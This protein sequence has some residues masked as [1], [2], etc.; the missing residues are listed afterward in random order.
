[1]Y[2]NRLFHLVNIEDVI[3]KKP[4]KYGIDVTGRRGGIKASFWAR[5]YS[6]FHHKGPQS[7]PHTKNNSIIQLKTTEY[8]TE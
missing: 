5:F 1:M 4:I 2:G 7:A 6:A 8:K 3:E